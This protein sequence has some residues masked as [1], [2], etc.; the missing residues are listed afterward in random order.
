ML[1]ESNIISFEN[2]NIDYRI[3]FMSIENCK[4]IIISIKIISNDKKIRKVVRAHHIIIILFKLSF[5]I[6]VRLRDNI[7]L[8]IDRDLMFS[9]YE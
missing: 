7:L 8:F 3:S 6:S 4:S 2:I 1:I 9:F 5:L